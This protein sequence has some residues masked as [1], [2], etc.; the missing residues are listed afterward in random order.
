MGTNLAFFRKPQ[1][2]MFSFFFSSSLVA[3]W[4]GLSDDA[5]AGLT[6]QTFHIADMVFFPPVGTA[7]P[8]CANKRSNKFCRFFFPS[9]TAVIPLFFPLTTWHLSTEVRSLP[10]ESP[11]APYIE[12][13]PLIV[14]D[15]LRPFLGASDISRRLSWF[16][17][18]HETL[19][20]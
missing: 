19:F 9:Q 18:V 6:Q 17:V 15:S 20:S 10:F 2:S 8:R 3:G 13:P 1:R 16:P 11:S 14:P 5:V 4:A 7:S 12:A